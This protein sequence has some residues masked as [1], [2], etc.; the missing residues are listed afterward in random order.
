MSRLSPGNGLRHLY[1]S[2]SINVLASLG[3]AVTGLGATAVMAREL[4]M[5]EFGRVLLLI[6]ATNAFAIFEGLRPVVIYRVAAKL[7]HYP[8]LFAGVARVNALMAAL[9]I[10]CLLSAVALDWT[11][12]TPTP[13]LVLLGMTVL[14]FFASMQY[15]SFLDAAADTLFTGM[16]RGLGWI[17][18]YAA[19]AILAIAHCGLTAFAFSLLLMNS[20]QALI[21]RQRLHSCHALDTSDQ[22]GT[23]PKLTALF[24]MAA[25]NV[26][27]NMSAVTINVADR[28]IIGTFLGAGPAGLYAGPSELAM[29]ASG[30]VRS[31]VQVILPWAARQSEEPGHRERL[32]LKA[33]VTVL[34]VAGTACSGVLA[35]RHPLTHTLLGPGFESSGNLLGLL[36]LTVVTSALGYACIVYLNARGN[37]HLQRRLYSVAA[38]ALVGGALYGA[39][40]ADLSFVAKSF[41][42]ARSV[43]LI[44]VVAILVKCKARDV[45]LFLMMAATI[46]ASLICAW[47]GQIA[48][49]TLLTLVASL[50]LVYITRIGSMSR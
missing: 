34:L 23:A 27:F 28:A 49:V 42:V 19:F 30:L 38:V 16:V 26:A 29:R 33:V 10:A 5:V 14:A 40:Q 15:W 45:I 9:C 25:N 8:S 3:A 1:A 48:A 37:F 43:D 31:A 18:L 24:R 17:A 6:T 32:W 21:F 12:E 36:S 4:S 39:T 11:G 7:D 20:A 46:I 35:F 44:L 22:K 13:A 41:V 2:A 47:Y 50:S